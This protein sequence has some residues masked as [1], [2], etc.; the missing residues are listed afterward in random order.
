MKFKL[1]DTRHFYGGKHQEA[2]SKD[3]FYCINPATEEIITEIPEANE[4]DI[5][6][7]VEAAKI[8][9]EQW[10]KIDPIEKGRIISSIADVIEE[11][12]EELAW[13]DVIDA[14][15]PILDAKEDIEAV[16]RMFRYF[17]GMTDKIEGYTIPVSND[18]TVITIR[19]PYGVIAA[20]TAWNYPLFNESAKIAPIIATGN[21]CI[22]K[23]AE[24]TPLVAL[25]L[26][27]LIASV[28][29]IPKGLVSVLNGRGETTGELLVANSDISKVTFTGSTETAH[30]ILRNISNNSLKG[31]TFELGG[32]APVVVFEDANIEGA[33]KAIAFCGFFN[34]GQTCT[35][36][37]R[38]IVQ[39][40]VHDDLLEKIKTI[41][42]R[43]VVGN[44]QDEN[45]TCG[46]LV[47]KAQFDKVNGYIKRAIE[48]GEQLYL[49]GL[50][51]R[52]SKGYFVNP[53]IFDNINP[54][55]ELF[56]DEIFGPVLTITCFDTIDEAITLANTSNYGLACGIWTKDF[57]KIHNTMSKINCGIVWCNTLFAEFPG[58]PAGGYKN[59][60]YGRE[61]GKEAITEYTQLKTTWL[62]ADDNYSDWV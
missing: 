34:Q 25:R 61:Y 51:N 40:S 41:A 39:R 9:F 30:N 26:A 18:R 12:S 33:A 62:C 23:P 7:A 35:A 43:I 52:N 54:Q 45:T 2:M 15:R 38:I 49:G 14:G 59:S 8:A 55:S 31:T 11:H 37:T 5:Q 1:P 47:S 20:I 58:A 44:P 50:S 60:G 56:I 42:K 32:K 27:E 28:P 6:A 10:K 48:R 57:S 13:I 46:P 29:N 17:A 53:T 4:R 22:L 3:V 16:Q 19:E 36:A 24:E 21:A